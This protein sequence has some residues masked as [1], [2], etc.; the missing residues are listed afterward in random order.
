MECPSKHRRGIVPL[1]GTES[2]GSSHSREPCDPAADSSIQS[3]PI[4]LAGTYKAASPL[5]QSRYLAAEPVHCLSPVLQETGKSVSDSL[6]TEPESRI[7]SYVVG[8]LKDTVL[9]LKGLKSTGTP[10]HLH[11]G[12]LTPLPGTL[13]S[14]P[15]YFLQIAIKLRDLPQ[16]QTHD[17]IPYSFPKAEHSSSVGSLKLLPLT[18]EF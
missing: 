4:L 18:R 12:A 1:R 16:L 5:N 7:L 9:S 10:G 15:L 13:S 8:L 11:F 3:T 6:Q 17:S 2:T 14:F